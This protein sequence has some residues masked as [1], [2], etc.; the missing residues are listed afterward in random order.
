MHNKC[1]NKTEINCDTKQCF[2]ED[3]WRFMARVHHEMT[4]NAWAMSIGDLRTIRDNISSLL[5][6]AISL[7]NNNEV[8]DGGKAENYRW[9]ADAQYILINLDN[10]IAEWIDVI[11][12]VHNILDKFIDQNK[13]PFFE[14]LTDVNP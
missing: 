14:P 8:Y 10:W 9:L 7:T 5:Y 13:C 12:R 11:R 4:H 3:Y 1:T 2:Y 6:R